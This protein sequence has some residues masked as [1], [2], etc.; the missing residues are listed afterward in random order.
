MK[1]RTAVAILNWNGRE[2]LRR[3]LPEVI[4][5]TSAA[6]A[7][8]VVADNGSTDG[9]ADMLRNEF[10]S[11]EVIEFA[12]N[13]GY[14]GG[15]N[16]V[17][18]R[19]EEEYIVLLN[20]DVAPAKDWLSPLIA[21]MDAEPFLAACQPKILSAER[22][23][24]FEYAGAAG[25]FIDRHGYPYCRGR[26]FTE[27]ETDTGQYAD[28]S[29][30]DWAS[31]AALMV[32][33]SHFLAAGGFDEEFF[34]HM[35]E[36]DLCLRFKRMGLKVAVVPQSAV[37]HLGGGALPMESPRKTYLNFRNNLLMLRK[38]VHESE[39]KSLLTVR[40]LLDT[41]AWAKFVVTGK[42]KHASAILRAHRDYRSMAAK[43]KRPGSS[44]EA[45]DMNYEGIS[46]RRRPDLLKEYYL[47]RRR[48]FSE[49]KTGSPSRV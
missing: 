39:R 35:E 15:Y 37:Y 48:K 7:R 13:Y 22:P 23:D 9:S 30:V 2:M 29:E 27:I 32:R 47:R 10:P 18:E 3:F 46:L 42:W 41:L 45:F 14:A 21:A 43:Y 31:G 49:I 25:G 28:C 1:R 33:R 12:E 20:S 26:I 4:D 44:A 36:I 17:V 38:N 40:R 24:K 8:I 19:L 16:R 11:V 5:A 34:A 6:A